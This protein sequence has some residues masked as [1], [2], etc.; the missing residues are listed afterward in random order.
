[1]KPEPK[2][3]ASDIFDC[4]QCGDCCHGYG[5]TYVSDEDVKNISVFINVDPEIFVKEYCQISGG[6]YVLAIGNNGKC[7]FYND[8]TQCT[9]HPVKPYM[10]KAWPFIEGVVRNPENWEVMSGS[11]PGIRA[12]VPT[13]DVVRCVK[14]ELEKMKKS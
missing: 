3:K 2:L 5:G 12:D 4:K 11:C 9:I 8:E 13:K 1:M 10:C 14:S 7:L 6:R